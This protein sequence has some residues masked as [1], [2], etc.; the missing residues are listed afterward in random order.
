ML[1]NSKVAST[2]V[3]VGLEC[4]RRAAKPLRDRH[5]VCVCW[6]RKCRLNRL[7]SWTADI[8]IQTRLDC[9]LE[10]NEV[11]HLNLVL[12]PFCVYER[13]HFFLFFPQ[14]LFI[15][16]GWKR[17]LVPFK[18]PWS[19]QKCWKKGRKGTQRQ[20]ECTP[21]FR[22]YR[23]KLAAVTAHAI[24]EK[25]FQHISWKIPSYNEFRNLKAC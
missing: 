10:S 12:A 5:L 16:K 14:I 18:W 22:A 15:D 20:P 7:W 2:L 13:P 21:A 6:K 24:K 11:M 8:R 23:D 3:S 17:G 1:L 4:Q 19:P 25:V 9:L